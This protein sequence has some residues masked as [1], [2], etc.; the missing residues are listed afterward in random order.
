MRNRFRA[1]WIPVALVL[2]FPVAAWAGVTLTYSNL[3]PPSHVHSKLAEAWCK[4]IEKRTNGEV[5]F[6]YFPGQTLTK[7]KQ[8]YD[9]VVSGISDVALSLFGYTPG[10]FPVMEAVDLPFGYPNAKAATEAIN[11]VYRQLRPKELDDVK[12]LYL[13]AHGPG[14]LNSRSKA[15]RSLEDLRGLKFRATGF[16]AK[17][18]KALGGTPVAMPMPETYQALSKGVVDGGLFPMEA[19][20]GWR[21]GE[22]VKYTTLNYSMAYT[23]GFFV[24]M[25]KDK[26]N[27]LSDKAKKVIDQV[28]QEWIAKTA[29]AWDQIDEEGRKYYLEKQGGHLVELSPNEAARWKRAVEPVIEEYVKEKEARGLPGRKAVEI[30]RTVLKK[31]Q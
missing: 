29:A 17:I 3:F 2:W 27:A 30:V 21:L 26:W 18:V 12:V 28:S 13:H 8:A 14:L 7:G 10:R 19:L 5:T 25:N 11:E 9:G 1:A 23:S 31:Y 16:A 24:V 4:E 6:Q 15:V 22:V 20:R